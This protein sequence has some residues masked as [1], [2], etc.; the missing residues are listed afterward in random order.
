MRFEWRIKLV[1][2]GNRIQD[3]LRLS[4]WTLLCTIKKSRRFRRNISQ[5]ANNVLK[6]T[7]VRVK[8][9]VFQ[10]LDEESLVILTPKFEPWMD[11]YLTLKRG[12][13]F[14]DV[15]AHIGKYTVSLAKAVG[16]EGRVIAIEPHPENFKTLIKNVRL[17]KL[18]NVVA[19]N[20]AC[21]GDNQ[22]LKLFVGDTT[23]HH[24]LK[25]NYGFG[26]ISVTAK[27]L[28]TILREFKVKRVDFVK[29]DVEGSELEVFE[30]M[31]ETLLRFKPNIIVEVSSNEHLILSYVK[32]YGYNA[33][34]IPDSSPPYCLLTC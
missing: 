24:G 4:F 34:L 28:D 9:N 23:G 1:L 13:V 17:N 20:I 25:K 32:K 18:E 14:I 31:E 6:N 3:K 16:S 7:L 21:W 15:G 5:L 22:N 12:D 10:V 26:A 29:I 8:G 2:C 33:M 11:K 27:T 19:L 30:G